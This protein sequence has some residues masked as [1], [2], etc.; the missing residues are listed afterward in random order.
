[1]YKKIYTYR[2]LGLKL[3]EERRKCAKQPGY[4]FK[5]S[6]EPIIPNDIGISETLFPKFSKKCA[7]R[8]AVTPR[9]INLIQ[10]NSFTIDN[11]GQNPKWQDI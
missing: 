7:Y 3:I 5:A 11:L 1:M 6:T 8:R 4:S 9:F 2:V 10:S